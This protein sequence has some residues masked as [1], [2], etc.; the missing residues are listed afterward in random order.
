MKILVD[1]D[2]CPV[3]DIILK[4]AKEHG[5]ELVM[6]KNVCHEIYDDYAK[7]ITVEKG[8][9]V[10]DIALINNTVNGDI[11]VTQDYGVAAL[12]L[13]KKAAAINQNG[14][15]YTDDNIE[16]LLMKRYM[17]QQMRKKHKKY[18][19]TSKRSKDDDKIFELKFKE[20]VKSML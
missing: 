18:S 10:A 12:A 20:L 15:V 4:V 6:V 3:K 2:G 19:K 9:D 5:V 11:V 1:A 17:N 8:R 14:L 7:I 13:A 16:G